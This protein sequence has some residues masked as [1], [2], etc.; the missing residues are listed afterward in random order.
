M[1]DQN[2]TQLTQAEIVKEVQNKMMIIEEA[3]DYVRNSERNVAR[4][5]INKESPR[6][7][8]WALSLL[9]GRLANLQNLIDA[10]RADLN[11]IEV[12]E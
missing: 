6:E 8:R 4:G 5:V 7:T 10:V 3:F 12:T 11:S 1:T 9:A 2:K